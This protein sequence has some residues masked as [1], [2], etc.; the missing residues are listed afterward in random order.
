[1][2]VSGIAIDG[3]ASETSRELKCESKSELTREQVAK[4]RIKAGLP[5]QRL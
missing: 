2:F 3:P 1:M 5:P 4:A